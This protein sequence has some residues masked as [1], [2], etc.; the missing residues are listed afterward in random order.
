MAEARPY[1]TVRGIYGGVPEELLAAGGTLADAGVNAVWI[2]SGSLD[3]EQI[4][5]LREAI[6]EGKVDHPAA[7]GG[8]G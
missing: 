4:R 8:T 1:V 3:C 7:P 2:G 5:R 6:R